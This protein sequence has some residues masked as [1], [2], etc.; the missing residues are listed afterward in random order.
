M[1]RRDVVPLTA[2]EVGKLLKAVAGHRLRLLYW[3]ALILGLRQGE[4]L[5]LQWG[6]IDWEKQTL[7]VARQ[8]QTIPKQGTTITSTKSE[9]SVRLLPLPPALLRALRAYLTSERERCLEAGQVWTVERLLFGTSKM[10][11]MLPRNLVRH[12]Y[13]ARTKAELSED[14]DFH[15]LRHTVG[16]ALVEAG[17]N[18]ATIAAI[19]G[20]SGGSVTRRY[21]HVS[22]GAM[23][24]ALE[25]VERV[26][27]QQAA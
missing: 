16:A 26:W 3:L 1:R 6:D 22:Q 12:F 4:L 20:H 24:T 14:V 18:E 15:H 8:V 13:G 27:M 21:S 7:R 17:V 9:T 23:R 10:T 2:A 25:Q 11:P 19:L 5:G